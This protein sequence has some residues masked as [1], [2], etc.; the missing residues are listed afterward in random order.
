MNEHTCIR[1]SIVGWFIARNRRVR[2]TH[3]RVTAISKRH[4]STTRMMQYAR[5]GALSRTCAVA[6]VPHVAKQAGDRN[7][8]LAHRL[9]SS[10]S[11]HA[12]KTMSSGNAYCKRHRV[13]SQ[14]G[15]SGV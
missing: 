8:A 15:S 7:A 4:V 13:A 10:L 12:H 1:P 5:S 2:C 6:N 9:A 14:R 3:R 11:T